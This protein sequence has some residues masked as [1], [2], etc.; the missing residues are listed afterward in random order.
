M[1]L[2]LS[3]LITHRRHE[4][5]TKINT[6]TLCMNASIWDRHPTTHCP[7]NDVYV[8]SRFLKKTKICILVWLR[9]NDCHLVRSCKMILPVYG[10]Y[11]SI[12]N[13]F[14]MY[15]CMQQNIPSVFCHFIRQAH[16][17][18]RLITKRKWG[19]WADCMYTRGI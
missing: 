11:F 16:V 6:F 17:T 10:N 14:V 13:F 12:L 15:G 19:L 4:N 3:V 18:D 8:K 5:Q 9:L 7:G 1:R 2:P